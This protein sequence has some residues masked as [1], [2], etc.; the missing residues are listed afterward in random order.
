MKDSVYQSVL[1]IFFP[2]VYKGEQKFE[3]LENS[4]VVI[5]LNFL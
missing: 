2:N 5:S 3:S 1:G 4:D